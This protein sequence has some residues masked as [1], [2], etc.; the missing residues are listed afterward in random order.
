MLEDILGEDLPV[1]LVGEHCQVG[2]VGDELRVV[3]L[4]QVYVEVA[5][6]DVPS[7]SEVET[8]RM[9]GGAERRRGFHAATVAMD[10]A[11]HAGAFEVEGTRLL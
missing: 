3:E 6:A 11:P 8:V 2:H 10:H 1:V 9:G 7:A 5:L 4:V